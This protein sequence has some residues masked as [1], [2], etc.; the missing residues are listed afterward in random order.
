MSS[1]QPSFFSFKSVIENPKMEV[2]NNKL[3]ITIGVTLRPQNYVLC[4]LLN[5]C[6]T[7]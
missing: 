4:R 6:M 5:I 7:C 1:P 3:F 2:R